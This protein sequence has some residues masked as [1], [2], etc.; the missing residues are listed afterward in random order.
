M[1][2][3][4][5]TKNID[6]FH[7]TGN[8]FFTKAL[9]PR[10]F[11][12]KET[13]KLL[14]SEN[15]SNIDFDVEKVSRNIEKNKSNLFS[16]GRKTDSFFTEDSK[17]YIT[18][19][20]Y[21]QIQNK[22]KLNRTTRNWDSLSSKIV[23]D[24]QKYRKPKKEK[25]VLY[26]I[27]S[28]RLERIK[29]DISEKSQL[30]FG[31][32]TLKRAWNFSIVAAIL[33]GMF[34]MTLI[35]RY[36]GEGVSADK[37]VSTNNQVQEIQV[38]KSAVLGAQDS[39]DEDSDS[40]SIKY[41][42]DIIQKNENQK[43]EEFQD[44]I[45]KMVKGYPIEKMVPLIA[46]KDRIVAAFIIGIARQE[47]QWGKHIPVYQGKDCYNY[48]GYRGK[49]PV[50]T[51]GHS[52]FASPQDAVDT[53]A[54]RIEWLVKN[55]ELNTPSKMSIWKCGSACENDKN[56]KNWINNVDLYFRKLNK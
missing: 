3:K 40:D 36:L 29:E 45:E 14:E 52:C 28:N 18:P 12:Q 33:F 38:D 48:W 4:R 1:G 20:E 27:L 30:V 15:V 46:K 41:I 10:A 55:D 39:K 54:K 5:K 7:A 2:G 50:G 9:I 19:K 35:Y 34:S 8:I 47:S 49:N 56:V 53:V 11:S 22:I 16:R 32:F 42:E 17:L 26:D 25:D 24:Y 23:K 43:Q 37:L 6:S 44:E 21:R 13:K 31:T 51:G